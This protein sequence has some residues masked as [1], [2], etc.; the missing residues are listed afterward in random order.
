MPRFP[1]WLLALAASTIA[2]VTTLHAGE[3]EGQ[4]WRLSALAGTT[5]LPDREI[6]LTFVDGFVQGSDG[7]NRYRV[8]YRLEGERFELT[9]RGMSTMKA[10][11][12]PVMQQA[13]AFAAALR[14]TRT[15][16]AV[17]GGIELRDGQG[18]VLGALAPVSQALG[19]T[20]WR[21]TGYNNGKQAVTSV[22]SGT[23]LTLV[24]GEDG[25]LSG[26]AGCNRFNASWETTA[27]GIRIGPA[28]ATRR[29]CAEPEGVMQQESLFLQAL[30]R[31]ASS[32]VEGGRLELRSSGGALQLS[33]RRD[34]PEPGAG[35]QAPRAAVPAAAT[36]GDSPDSFRGELRYMADAASI[37]ECL[38][39]RSLPVAMEGAW[40][41]MERAYLRAASEPG[42]PL[43]V[44]FEGAIEQ[45]P[46]MEGE[47]TEASFVVSRFINA[48]PS[49]N[50]ERG[51]ADA[52]LTETYWRI[53]RVGSAPV[54]PAAGQREPHLVLQAGGGQ[55]RYRATV[56][57]NRMLGGYEIDDQALR[58]APGPV[59]RM[60]CPP[61][62][63]ALERALGEALARTALWHIEATTLELF[64]DRRRPLALFEAVYL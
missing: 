30:E 26:S 31:V 18:A 41:D 8:P 55:P 49:L 59:T 22:L 13:D 35:Q 2:A 12:P 9:G 6:T 11:P 61:P 42:G 45:R 33:A 48:W 1:R 57:C 24:F 50:C 52:E 17:D 25:R 58:F 14:A 53:V 36:A 47:G 63:D 21:V 37:E 4:G 38:S 34:A 60:A 27:G 16:R 19:G 3:L 29:M 62:L 10:C 64:D 20:A 15:L 28:A 43:F 40:T 51:R 46:K 56:G 44:T 54:F 39:G 23:T 32:R 5:L 7:C